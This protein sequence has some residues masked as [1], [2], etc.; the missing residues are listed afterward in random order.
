MNIEDNSGYTGGQKNDVK[1]NSV[2]LNS[3]FFPPQMLP[4]ILSM[5]MNL[6]EGQVSQII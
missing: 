1:K 2:N 5:P 6:Q 4:V 3:K